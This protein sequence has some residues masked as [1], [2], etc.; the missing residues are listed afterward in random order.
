[1]KDTTTDRRVR[2]T[3]KML[4]QA[5]TKLLLEKDIKDISVMELTEFA[6]INRGTFYLHYK[7][8]YD[9]YEQIENELLD[10]FKNIFDKHFHEKHRQILFPIVLEAFEFLAKNADICLVIL[11]SGDTGFLTKLIELG[12]PKKKEE[13]R[14]F[15]GEMDEEYYEYYYSYI[16][17]GCVGL[18]R[19]WFTGGMKESP[20]K[21][22]ELAGKMIESNKVTRG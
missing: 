5:L 3:K 22:A 7:D 6:D 4:R 20:K 18:L 9:L 17:S 21:M 15:L 2:K 8:I 11:S 1:M 13:W 14:E 12:K 10:K 19:T 16:T